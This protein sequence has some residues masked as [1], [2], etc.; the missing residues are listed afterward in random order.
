MHLL[1]MRFWSRLGRICQSAKEK[2]T[3][4]MIVA[5]QEDEWVI[6]SENGDGL[7]HHDG[8]APDRYASCCSRLSTFFVDIDERFVNYRRYEEIPRPIPSGKVRK[9]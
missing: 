5:N 6:S 8:H 4:G 1:T 9:R 3:A 2:D 7:G